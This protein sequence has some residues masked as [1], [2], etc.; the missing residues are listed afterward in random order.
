MR[1]SIAW[2]FSRE[3]FARV[4]SFCNRRVASELRQLVR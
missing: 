2:F 1:C 4:W 3:C